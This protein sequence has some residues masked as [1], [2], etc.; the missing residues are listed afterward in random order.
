MNNILTQN[1][2][3]N[4]LGIGSSQINLVGVA[5]DSFD[6]TQGTTSFMSFS[7]VDGSRKI[8]VKKPINLNNN[9]LT[10][11]STA[12]IDS[13]ATNSLF[14][15]DDNS[16]LKTLG[17]GTTD[18]YLRM[19]FNRP[20]W[21]PKTFVETNISG[22]GSIG[23]LEE[24]KIDDDKLIG[25][26]ST[27]GV[28]SHSSAIIQYDTNNHTSLIMSNGVGIG[29]LTFKTKYDTNFLDINLKEYTQDDFSTGESNKNITIVD[30]YT[31]KYTINDLADNDIHYYK[32]SVND[33]LSDATST[34]TTHLITLR[35][36]S[37]TPNAPSI[38][39]GTT[40]NDSTP[41]ITG[42]AETNSTITLT[43]PNA[44]YTTTATGG[45]W[46][47]DTGTAT[48]ASGSLSLNVN[49][50]NS[51]SVIATD[52]AGNVSDS[53]T[54]TLTIDTTSPNAPVFTS[55][56]TT[57]VEKPTITGTAEAGST[58]T[59]TVPNNAKYTTTATGGNWSVNL[60]TATPASGSLSLNVNGTNSISV[61]ATDSADNDSSPATQTLTIDTTS[62]SISI[63]SFSWGTTL[64]YGEDSSDG[65]VTVTTNGVENGQVITLGLNSNNYTGSVS[66]SSNNITISAA[67]LQGLS[68]QNYT[69]TANVSDAAGNAATEAS[70]TVSVNKTFTLSSWL[71]TSK[72]YK[73]FVVGSSGMTQKTEGGKKM[74][75]SSSESNWSSN[76]KIN[77][78]EL[79]S[80]TRSSHSNLN[81]ISSLHKSG[82][83]YGIHWVGE[84]PY[85]VAV[86]DSGYPY[87]L[88]DDHHISGEGFTAS[89][90]DQGHITS[91][92][93][94]TTQTYFYSTQTA[95]Y[96][97]S[98][99]HNSV[100]NLVKGSQSDAYRFECRS[101]TRNSSKN[102]F[103][104]VSSYGGSMETGSGHPYGDFHK[105][106]FSS[107]WKG[108]NP[109]GP[110]TLKVNTGYKNGTTW[111][112]SDPSPAP[113][114]HYEC[115]C[116]TIK[117]D[118]N[119]STY[120]DNLSHPNSDMRNIFWLET[121][122]WSSSRRILYFGVD[123][124]G[125]TS[126]GGGNYWTW[127]NYYHGSGAS[128]TTHGNSTTLAPTEFW[129]CKI[130]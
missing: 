71:D 78:G 29:T 42:T 119:N 79:D 24:L 46:S 2:G 49:G 66:G 112:S 101:N 15:I 58:V 85:W 3:N 77:A 57:N 33:L 53:T 17:I 87:G 103:N 97:G 99:D 83:G 116:V 67:G 122:S 45:N 59:L 41:T 25:I 16:E 121:V 129:I 20:A 108:G 63:S 61:I 88:A 128:S 130:P 52:S 27:L 47:I 70:A 23:Y 107:Q 95:Q 68:N 10:I 39:S 56:S 106:E 82:A 7:T 64:E 123:G 69:L 40:T 104:T 94:S 48:P 109:T 55:S 4:Q 110:S 127:L 114:I 125:H 44:T 62:P 86:T 90:Y 13:A 91:H 38:T 124:A 65:T 43:V 1:D 72:Q 60:N 120:G 102:V 11:K 126:Y 89:Q 22:I 36:D 92:S 21:G 74:T 50:T 14:Y 51:I 31:Y 115:V 35:R 75:T 111:T 32:L 6:I 117:G 30:N 81:N 113:E 19:G 9:L 34:K 18:E 80:S 118:Y 100:F 98:N 93:S 12:K 37:T 105:I 73:I 96:S 76:S 26:G 54:Q 8:S 5:N 28:K 84:G